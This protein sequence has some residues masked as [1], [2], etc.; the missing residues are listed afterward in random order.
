[1]TDF[2]FKSQPSPFKLGI[3][4]RTNTG[5]QQFGQRD[6]TSFQNQSSN[7]INKPIVKPKLPEPNIFFTPIEDNR[8]QLLEK[9]K[10]EM[11]Y[12]LEVT[13]NTLPPR[14]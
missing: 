6:L 3:V 10:R 5:L 4:E 13:K 14:Y 7:I 11:E 12:H 1:M 8:D 9:M 2:K